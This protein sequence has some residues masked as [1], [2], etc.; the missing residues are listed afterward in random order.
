MRIGIGIGNT[1]I[2]GLVY[3]ASVHRISGTCRKVRMD[4]DRLANVNIRRIRANSRVRRARWRRDIDTYRL[5]TV[6]ARKG[7]GR[8]LRERRRRLV[9]VRA[10]P[11]RSRTGDVAIAGILCAPV[12]ARRAVVREIA[13]VRP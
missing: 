11:I 6:V 7:I 12:D 5:R 9:A 3:G 10:T 4:T 1:D 8:V 13:V 2:C